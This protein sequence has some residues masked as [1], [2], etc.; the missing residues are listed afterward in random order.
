[1]KTTQRSAI[2]CPAPLSADDV[3]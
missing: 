1:M 3:L 2:S